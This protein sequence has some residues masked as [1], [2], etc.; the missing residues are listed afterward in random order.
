MPAWTRTA[1]ASSTAGTVSNRKIPDVGVVSRSLSVGSSQLVLLGSLPLQALSLRPWLVGM[2]LVIVSVVGDV[3]EDI[4]SM[5]T[6]LLLSLHV[7][8]HLTVL[9]VVLPVLACFP[10]VHL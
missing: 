9:L 10:G 6:L 4:S 8:A 3:G 5:A 2:C 7:L 1:V